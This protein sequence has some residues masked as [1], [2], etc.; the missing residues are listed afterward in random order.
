MTIQEIEE[1]VQGE[2]SYLD[3]ST[4]LKERYIKF[5]KNTDE[6]FKYRN[7]NNIDI[8]SLFLEKLEDSTEFFKIQGFD[9]KTSLEYAKTIVIETNSSKY[10]DKLAFLRVTNLQER[11]IMQNSLSLRFNLDKT[12]A[13][14]KYLI[15]INDRKSQTTSVLIHDSDERFKK[16]FNIDPTELI[17]KYPLNN[18]SY[19]IW[20]MIATM[21]DL[22]FQEYFKLTREQLSYI[23]PT[24]KDEVATL[25]FIANL[26]DEEILERYDITREQL[27]EKHPLNND[28]LKAL[29]SLKLSSNKAIENT[30]N[31]TRQELLELRTIT[32]EMIRTAQQKRNHLKSI[33]KG[34]YP[35]G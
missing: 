29:K 35:I 8:K 9:E 4:K 6:H 12:H 25:H 15:E 13:R 34:T 28:T 17:K 7:I 27:L 30:F 10:K 26:T 22:K 33:K 24:T 21:N 3:L 32:T 16:R 14:K 31:Q 1:F 19:V 20:M 23:Y 11:V 2:L 18:E 5:I